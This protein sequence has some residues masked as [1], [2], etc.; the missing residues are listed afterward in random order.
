M[1]KVKS[2][3]RPHYE[4]LYIVSNQFTED[5]VKPIVERIN[6]SITENGGEITYS[7][8]WGK[9]RLAYQIDNFT[10]G[11]YQL[12]E[13]D[14]DGEKAKQIDTNLRMSSDIIR[15]MIVAKKARTEEEIKEEKRK[16][17]EAVQK[18]EAEEKEK[19][20]EAVKVEEKKPEPK[21]VDMKELDEKLDKIL[22]TDDLL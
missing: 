3:E 9:K 18:T 20:E 1:A 15:H 17:E 19:K 8:D 11:Y 16:R 13:F 2:S 21:K 7:E 22:E 12:V 14:L 4:L 5:E 10:H 6:K